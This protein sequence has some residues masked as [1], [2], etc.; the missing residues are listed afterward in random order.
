M[1][2]K[3]LQRR[4]ACAGKVRHGSQEE[5]TAHAIH[6]RRKDGDRVRAYRCPFCRSWH[7]G[8]TPHARRQA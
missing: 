6:L 8:H 3:R 4:K 1:A 7:V 2:S 5:A